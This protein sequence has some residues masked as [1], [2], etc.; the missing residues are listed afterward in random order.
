MRVSWGRRLAGLLAIVGFIATGPGLSGVELVAHLSGAV[1]P[2]H[3]RQTHVEAAGSTAHADH[4][5]LGLTC[6][7]GRLA[8]VGQEPLRHHLIDGRQAK[9][10]TTPTTGQGPGGQSLPRAPPSVQTC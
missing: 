8:P 7:D 4:C 5:Q 9:A 3:A 10:S 1:D 6:G 2:A